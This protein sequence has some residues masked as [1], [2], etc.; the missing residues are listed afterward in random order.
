MPE[1]KKLKAFPEWI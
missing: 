1:Y